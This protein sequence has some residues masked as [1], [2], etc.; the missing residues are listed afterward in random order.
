MY[1]GELPLNN[2]EYMK[3]EKEEEYQPEGGEI[4]NLFGE[5]T[6]NAD[7]NTPE[8]VGDS[9]ESRDEQLDATETLPYTDEF[10]ETLNLFDESNEYATLLTDVFDTE[11]LSEIENGTETD[12]ESDS[13]SEYDEEYSEDD[14]DTDTDIGESDEP[15]DES[16]AEGEDTEKDKPKPRRVD[17]LFDFLEICIFTLAGVFILMS[18]FFRYSIVDGGSMM[19]TLQ[20]QERL[21][22]T[23]FLYTPE[24]G[25]IVV[26]QD[27]STV[28]KDPIVKRVIAVGGQTVRFTRTD[29]YVDGVK[30]DEPYVYT[31]DYV[32]PFG[33]ADQYRYSVYPSDALLDIVVDSQDGVYYE[34]LV[35][36]GEIF[37]MGDH[38][39]NSKDSR[40]IGTLHEEAII[41][42]AVYRFFP[43]DK[44]GKIE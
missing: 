37:V 38:R 41:G 9:E 24:C 5:S 17:S 40:D 25:D 1:G 7:E 4:L 36:D 18:F 43:F 34:I 16:L 8:N 14:E 21:L 20:H 28:L 6:E 2:D 15:S 11:E 33:G 35:P 10:S 44:I 31:G 12:E 19:N 42:K 32:N 23:N 26:V 27:K 13:E 3:N 39:N 30:L 22:L 29:V